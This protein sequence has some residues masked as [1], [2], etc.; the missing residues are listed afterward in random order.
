[1][2]PSLSEEI[3]IELQAKNAELMQLRDQATKLQMFI[4]T[5]R[6]RAA[7]LALLSSSAQKSRDNRNRGQVMSVEEEI[8]QHETDLQEVQNRIEGLQQAIDLLS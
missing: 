7:E 6:H 3:N 4:N 8:E 1:M 5:L 2:A